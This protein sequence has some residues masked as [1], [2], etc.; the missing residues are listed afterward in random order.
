MTNL[1]AFGLGHAN[2]SAADAILDTWFPAPLLRPDADTAA[3]IIAIT[4]IGDDISGTPGADSMDGAANDDTVGW[5]GV[6]KVNCIG[7]FSV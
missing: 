6:S 2:L 5:T 3:G 1:F 4:G 7:A